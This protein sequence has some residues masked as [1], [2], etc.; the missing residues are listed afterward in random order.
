MAIHPWWDNSHSVRAIEF[1]IC[2]EL[3]HILLRSY[4]NA[5]L[6]F[7][8]S[9]ILFHYFR[10]WI[11]SL[12]LWI[13]GLLCHLASVL[14]IGFSVADFRTARGRSCSSKVCF[15]LCYFFHCFCFFSYP[16]SS[17]QRVPL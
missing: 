8:Y 14:P 6:V 17:T 3:V 15:L 13:L 2:D 9:V 12:Q 5:S 7:A 11:I 1:L 16:P 4:S 10:S